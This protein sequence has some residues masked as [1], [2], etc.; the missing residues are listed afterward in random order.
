MHHRA[1]GALLEERIVFCGGGGAKETK[2]TVRRGKLKDVRY[3]LGRE[4]HCWKGGAL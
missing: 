3:T 1:G 4:V 2:C